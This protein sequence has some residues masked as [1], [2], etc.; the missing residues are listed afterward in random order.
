M[1]ILPAID[2][3]NGSCVRL[4]QGEKDRVKVYDQDPVAMAERFA[5]A[6]AEMLHLV[7]LD[8]AFAGGPSKNLEIVARIVGALKIPVE[9]GGGV[10]DESAVERLVGLGVAR[11]ILGTIAVEAP[12]LV[13]SLVARYGSR[14]VVG[15]D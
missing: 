7:D 8:G 9:F 12:E 10:R 6:G 5:S 1:L 14:V 2:L 11:I 3:K 15:I 4:T 13:A